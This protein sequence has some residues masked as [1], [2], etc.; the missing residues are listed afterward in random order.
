MKKLNALAV[1]FVVSLVVCCLAFSLRLMAQSRQWTFEIYALAALIIIAAVSALVSGT[2]L[3]KSYQL[4]QGLSK[5]MSYSPKPL[6]AVFAVLF[7]VVNTWYAYDLF[8]AAETRELNTSLNAAL[9]ALSGVA[10]SAALILAGK[11]TEGLLRLCFLIMVV[12]CCQDLI[13]QYSLNSANP[14]KTSYVWALAGQGISAL[15]FLSVMALSATRKF[16]TLRMLW[17]YLRVAA[18]LTAIAIAT[19]LFRSVEATPQAELMMVRVL[20]LWLTE[21]IIIVNLT[22]RS[23]IPEAK[24]NRETDISVDIPMPEEP[25]YVPDKYETATEMTVDDILKEIENDIY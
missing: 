19:D 16:T 2:V 18:V 25:E 6:I 24:I 17:T 20:T 10:F 5:A 23:E 21:R 3:S 4:P 9:A 11:R 15:A 1:S 8:L 14:D 12:Y 22:K 13:M 7:A